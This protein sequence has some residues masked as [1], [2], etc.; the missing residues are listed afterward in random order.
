MTGYGVAEKGEFRVEVRSLNHKHLDISIKIPASLMK[1]EVPIRTMIK[2]WFS[3]GKIDV[4]ISFTG[5]QHYKVSINRELAVSLYDAFSDIQRT[6]SIPGALPIDFLLGFKELILT[7]ESECNPNVLYEALGEG[8]SQV[9]VMR[10]KEG[11]M[12]QREILSMVGALEQMRRE[13][14]LCSEGAVHMQKSALM[15]KIS[16]LISNVTIDE[17]RLVQEVALIVQ[18]SDITEELVRLASHFN[19][20]GAAISHVDTAGRKIDFICQEMNREVNTI[21][22]KTEDIR[23]KELSIAMKT[24]IEK[25][26]EQAQNIQ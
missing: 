26:R 9:K 3:R 2:Q 11:A 19:Q 24:E 12:L 5:S 4:I 6:L 21:A 10:E 23:I 17:S 8:L 1:H 15:R 20:V 16:D 14:V 22:S 13:V 25:V 7:E 18:K